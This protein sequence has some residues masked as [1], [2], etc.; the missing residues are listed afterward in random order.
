[1]LEAVGQAIEV[2]AGNAHGSAP[3]GRHPPL[4]AERQTEGQGGL[5]P[6][7][8][9]IPNQAP[10]CGDAITVAH[11]EAF[12]VHTASQS[13]NWRRGHARSRVP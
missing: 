5:E 10:R 8:V 7:A 6:V 4:I 13:H 1:V 2:S 3:W 12:D 9:P 11:D